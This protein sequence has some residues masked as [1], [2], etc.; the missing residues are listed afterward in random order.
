VAA[1]R[2][3]I[4]DF[5][6]DGL[7]IVM[8]SGQ[9]A[10]AVSLE[11]ELRSA[12]TPFARVVL[13]V[14]HATPSSSG[15]LIGGKLS[16]A[17]PL[18]SGIALPGMGD[19]LQVRDDTIFRAILT[20]LRRVQPPAVVHSSR[21]VTSL[22][23]VCGAHFDESAACL[24]VVVDSQ[25]VA[26]NE[27]VALDVELFGASFSVRG[28]A[29]TIEHDLVTLQALKIF[30]VGRRQHGRVALLDHHAT[31]E[32]RHPLDPSHWI[33]TP[34]VELSAK[35]LAI[36][37]SAK[38]RLLLPPPNVPL[39]L[40]VGG[41]HVPV[42]AEVRH[43]VV[44]ENGAMRVGLSMTPQVPSDTMYIAR[45]CQSARF[46]MLVPRA[47]VAPE[48]V[49]TL[50]RASGYLALRD[51]T[52]PA[53]GWHAP[54]ANEQLT[55]DLIYRNAGKP[56]AHGSYLRIY[57]NTW[58]FHQLATTGFRRAGAAYPLYVQAAEWALALTDSQ[59]FALSYFDQ[60]KSWHQTM[61]GEFQSWVGSDSLS[62]ITSLD[63]L[64]RLETGASSGGDFSRARVREALPSE[65]TFVACLARSFL[66]TLIADGLHISE[67]SVS[68]DDLCSQHAL[69]GLERRRT[70]LVVELDGQLEAA[71]L[72]ETG[73]RSLSL[74][75]I[76]N[77]A[78]IFV[79]RDSAPQK[80]RGAQAA[81]LRAVLAFYE[82][83]GVPDPI[84]ATPQGSIW[85][86]EDAG[87]AVTESMGCWVASREGLKQWKNYIHYALG[88]FYRPASRAKA[89]LSP[90][91][92]GRNQ[93]G[94]P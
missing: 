82:A 67:T 64:E 9:W 26:L 44:Q 50:M 54:Q 28:V 42:H 32:W 18:R 76:L 39:L 16:S 31:L 22:G 85:F 91:F 20:R 79:R 21:G 56:V 53:P 14:A 45:S 89:A 8:P 81:L 74:F 52:D 72:C 77:M 38:P 65:R 1:C 87:L 86:P 46:P 51:R 84:V 93:G 47:Q 92:V 13:E 19:S 94:T 58:L 49:D 11:L 60:G 80:S 40:R 7:G 83:R 69:A 17:F 43:T 78:H 57:Q 30:S 66:P 48:A 6:F 10:E 88:S 41:V 23:R 37:L 36:E 3:A 2:V 63:R 62:M 12:R 15:H 5:S 24:T 27:A 25:H 33:S 34:V 71:A 29:A 70:A 55:I 59:V 4:A 61:L 73:S 75:N 68:V 90:E 35:G